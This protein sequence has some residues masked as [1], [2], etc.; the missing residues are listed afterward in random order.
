MKQYTLIILMRRKLNF[1]N[2]F[3]MAR[4]EVWQVEE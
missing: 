2:K 3:G 1:K 4:L